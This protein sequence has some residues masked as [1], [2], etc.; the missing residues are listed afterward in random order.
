VLLVD[1]N[2]LLYAVNSDATHHDESRAWLDDALGGGEPVGFTWV[3]L[4]AFLR[5]ATNPSAM[6]D[7]LDVTVA[8]DQVRAWMA[9]PAAIVVE[10][11]ARHAD[12][13]A[14]LLATTGTAGNLVSD[15]HLAALAAEHSATIV[16][17]DGDFT[18]FPGIR[19]RRPGSASAR[20]KRG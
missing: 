10:P 12:V 19:S 14:G 3:V 6:P 16:S 13:L 17:F 15:A 1:A 7:P 11:T 2:V 4:L 18:R 20:S 5:V 9:A 8:S